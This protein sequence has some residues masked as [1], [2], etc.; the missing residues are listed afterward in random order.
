MKYSDVVKQTTRLNREISRRLVGGGCQFPRLTC[1][2]GPGGWRGRRSPA[3]TRAPIFKVI[4]YS[5]RLDDPHPPTPPPPPNPLSLNRCGDIMAQNALWL[6]RCGIFPSVAGYREQ[7]EA[8]GEAARVCQTWHDSLAEC[9]PLPL[10]PS[11]PLPPTPFSPLPLILLGSFFFIPP[12]PFLML[13]AAAEAL[14]V[15]SVEG[16]NHWQHVARA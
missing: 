3:P 9:P 7:G 14:N 8:A 6:N 5:C 15:M 11:P 16:G 4:A 10:T 1:L 2:R 13:I 12:A